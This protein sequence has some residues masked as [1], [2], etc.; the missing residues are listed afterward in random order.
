MR[1]PLRPGNWLRIAKVTAKHPPLVIPTQ[2]A[3]T[4]L[5]AG[6]LQTQGPVSNVFNMTAGEGGGGGEGEEEDC[7]EKKRAD[8]SPATWDT[9]LP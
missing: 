9:G 7:E 6:G 2:Q 5:K 8:H 1:L 4:R 3:V